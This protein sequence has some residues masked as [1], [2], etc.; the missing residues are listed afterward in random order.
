MHRPGEMFDARD[1]YRGISA[2]AHRIARAADSVHL[3][4][5]REAG[6]GKG[7]C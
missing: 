4:I 1:L 3:G 5:A 7:G 2:P 6:G